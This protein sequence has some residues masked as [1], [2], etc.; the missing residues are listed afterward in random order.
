LSQ[1]YYLVLLQ[2]HSNKINRNRIP[3]TSPQ[4]IVNG[5]KGEMAIRACELQGQLPYSTLYSPVKAA[6]TKGTYNNEIRREYEKNERKFGL[7]IDVQS[8]ALTRGMT[9]HQS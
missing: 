5:I 4:V 1:K 8:M 2:F 6:R 9:F 7:I 3:T